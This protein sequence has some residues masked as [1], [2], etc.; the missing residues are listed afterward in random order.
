MNFRQ[1]AYGIISFV[2]GVPE[3][4]YKGT[5]G[6]NSA[7]YSYC[8]WLRHLVLAHDAGMQTVPQ[9]VAELGPGDS[10]GVGIAA[11][12]CGAH[13]YL[14]LDAVAHADTATN[15][16]V[17]DTLVELFRRQTPIPDRRQ[18]PEIKIDLPVYAFPDTILG[19]SHLQVAL[20]DDRVAWLRSLVSGEQRDP[21]V[22]DYRAPWDHIN[23]EDAESV[24]FILTNAVMEHVADLPSAYTAM[25]RWLRPGGYASNQ[26][27][28]RSHSLFSAWDGHWACPAWLWRL[29]IGRRHY[30]LNREPFAVHRRLAQAA[31]FHEGRCTRIE[32]TPV[33]RH[34]AKRF[35]GMD[36]LDRSTS[37][38]YLLLRKPDV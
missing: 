4:L 25:H 24:D 21:T 28:F 15:L 34:L 29:F 3:S 23:D 8:I 10:I 31:G 11:L 6:T 32:S 35:R 30:L 20:A 13:R 38:G 1:L 18:F 33:A 2:P 5:G 17:F 26:I 27:D 16:R 22:L 19:A 9:A 14:A 37:G 12:L 7:E 36:A